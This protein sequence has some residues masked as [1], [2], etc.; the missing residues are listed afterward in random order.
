MRS[1]VL[2]GTG[3]LA[4]LLLAV[5]VGIMAA[6]G[7]MIRETVSPLGVDDTVARL[8]DTIKAAGWSLQ[9]IE[10]LDEKLQEKGQTGIRPTRLI[11]IC[12]AD[13][14]GPILRDDHAH[15]A[16]VLMPC[17]IAVYQKE[18]G[19]TYVATMNA[20]LMGRLFG[21]VIAEIMGG[22]VARDQDGFLAALTA[23]P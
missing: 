18:D 2:L 20:G 21:G 1:A 22:P 23:K 9:S 5:V 19:R 14:A 17:T 15:K 12:R 7:M 4:G 10:R 3:V 6:P 16:S 13:Y 8:Q 11:N